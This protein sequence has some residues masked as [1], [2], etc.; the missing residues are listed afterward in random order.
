VRNYPLMYSVLARCPDCG[1]DGEAHL[2][3]SPGDTVT[4]A[5]REVVDWAFACDCYYETRGADR[6]RY[7]RRVEADALDAEMMR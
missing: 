7:V 2:D 3:Y 4:P 5:L 1:A 6:S